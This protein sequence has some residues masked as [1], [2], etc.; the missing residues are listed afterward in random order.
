MLTIT[1]FRREICLQVLKY[2]NLRHLFHMKSKWRKG[3]RSHM[4]AVAGWSSYWYSPILFYLHITGIGC[5]Y[6]NMTWKG[7]LFSYNLNC[8]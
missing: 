2:N 5:L 6:E 1:E 4:P 7:E 8:C 3:L